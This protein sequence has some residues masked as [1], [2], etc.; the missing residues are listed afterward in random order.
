[1]AVLIP[2]AFTS[3]RAAL[4]PKL[5]SGTLTAVLLSATFRTISK[6]PAELER[7]DVSVREPRYGADLDFPNR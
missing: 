4:G 5:E 1:M 3:Y 2:R 6:D 7:A